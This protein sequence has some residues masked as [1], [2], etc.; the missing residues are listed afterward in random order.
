[1]LQDSFQR[2]YYGVTKDSTIILYL[3]M[4]GGSITYKNPNTNARKPNGSTSFK[5]T[6]KGKTFTFAD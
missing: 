3:R 1:M 4:E 5:D 2:K 6:L